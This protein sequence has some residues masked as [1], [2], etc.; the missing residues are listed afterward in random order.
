M[1]FG[2]AMNSFDA[3]EAVPVVPRVR[4]IAAIA[5]IAVRMAYRFVNLIVVSNAG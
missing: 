1:P 4:P 2:V 3:A 5:A